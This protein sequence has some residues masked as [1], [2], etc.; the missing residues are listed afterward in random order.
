MVMMPTTVT[1]AMPTTTTGKLGFLGRLSKDGIHGS[2]I[3][4]ICCQAGVIGRPGW[5]A[6]AKTQRGNKNE[7]FHE[8]YPVEKRY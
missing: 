2:R 7:F 4:Q 5:A 6:D 1:T 8:F 3:D